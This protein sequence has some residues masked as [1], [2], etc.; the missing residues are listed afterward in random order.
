MSGTYQCMRRKDWERPR[1]LGKHSEFRDLAVR[2][3]TLV[4]LKIQVSKW[5]RESESGELHFLPS[6]RFLYIWWGSKFFHLDSSSGRLFGRAQSLI[7]HRIVIL[8]SQYGPRR[9]FEKK[10][11]GT[12]RNSPQLLYF[13]QAFV[14]LGGSEISTSLRSEGPQSSFEED[15][16][17]ISRIHVEPRRARAA[18]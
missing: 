18:F 12:S 16:E 15:E 3:D 4:T 8:A 5:H 1:V 7:G 13:V 11:N 17:T 6:T 10:A 9:I 14:A 2:I